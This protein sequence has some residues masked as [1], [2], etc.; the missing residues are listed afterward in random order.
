MGRS[1]RAFATAASSLRTGDLVEISFADAHGHSRGSAIV[2]VVGLGYIDTDD[3]DV[4]VHLIMPQAASEAHVLAWLMRKALAPNCICFPG[5]RQPPDVVF[6]SSVN[7][8]MVERFRVRRRDSLTEPWAAEARTAAPAQH[9]G[10]PLPNDR[11]MTGVQC[12]RRHPAELSGHPVTSRSRAEPPLGS[13][14]EP[15]SPSSANQPDPG[16]SGGLVAA[17]AAAGPAGVRFCKL[18]KRWLNHAVVVSKQDMTDDLLARE[19]AE[20]AAVKSRQDMLMA[21]QRL[22]KAKQLEP[23]DAAELPEPE[24]ERLRST[25]P[26]AGKARRR[27]RH[28]RPEQVEKTKRRKRRPSPSSSSSSSL[29]SSSSGTSSLDDQP[30][31][32]ASSAVSTMKRSQQDAAVQP[33]LGLVAPLFGISQGLPKGSG[34]ADMAQVDRSRKRPAINKSLSKRHWRDRSAGAS[35]GTFVD[36]NGNL[37]LS[38]KRRLA[39]VPARRQKD[40]GGSAAPPPGEPIPSVKGKEKGSLGRNSSGQ[41]TR[42]RLRGGR[43]RHKPGGADAALAERGGN[44][45]PCPQ[46]PAGAAPKTRM[47]QEQPLQG[48]ASASPLHRSVAPLGSAFAGRTAGR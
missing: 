3:G 47:D 30:F 42:W 38:R 40:R 37:Q 10:A 43:R 15:S 25:K 27:R 31:R 45:P 2:E 13:R 9:R 39:S 12:D 32:G 22:A 16:H 14:G 28:S 34:G 44:D 29:S 19:A 24:H 23:V 8:Y 7:V 21:G 18:G 48:P 17:V 6:F 26:R 36:G 46:A 20:V 4:A 11:P 35:T 41:Q 33:H 1:Q 5:A